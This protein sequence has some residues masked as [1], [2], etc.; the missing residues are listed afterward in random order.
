MPL[1]PGLE[2]TSTVS[3]VKP[4]AAGETVSYGRT[5]AAAAATRIA[6]V[7]VGYGD[8]YSRLLS[9]RGRVLIGRGVPPGSW[10]GCAWTS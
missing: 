1:Q 10:A 8:G 3:F 5:W 2:W 4:L 6:T 7:P 9:N